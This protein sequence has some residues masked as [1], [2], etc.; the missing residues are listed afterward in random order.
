MYAF[1]NRQAVGGLAV[2]VFLATGI[3]PYQYFSK[4]ISQLMAAVAANRNLLIYRQV[5]LFDPF[6]VRFLLEM[7]LTFCVLAILIGGAWYIGY[8][9]IIVNSLTF[10]AS[11]LLLSF[12]AL[13][14]GLIFSV[15]V[16]SLKIPEPDLLYRP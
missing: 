10:L 5:R 14:I 7:V 6:L 1:G 11:F 13:G 2:P 3:A 8:K 9:V 15:I 16:L 4:V 12:F